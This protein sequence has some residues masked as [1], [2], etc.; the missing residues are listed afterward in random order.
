MYKYIDNNAWSSIDA[1]KAKDIVRDI[2]I[3]MNSSGSYPIK[4]NPVQL[5]KYYDERMVEIMYI[6]AGAS[7]GY[8]S[9]AE[10]DKILG[11]PFVEWLGQYS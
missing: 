8:Y 3:G 9:A 11:A 6:L 5:K 2:F 4:I 10:A 7:Y 1:D